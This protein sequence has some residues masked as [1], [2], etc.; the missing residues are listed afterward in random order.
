M[1]RRDDDILVE[2]DLDELGSPGP[3]RISQELSGHLDTHQ[4]LTA[5]LS[6]YPVSEDTPHQP[7][8]YRELWW[9]SFS[10][11]ISV[12]RTTTQP[13]PHLPKFSAANQSQA[14]SSQPSTAL[15]ND[16]NFPLLSPQAIKI[17]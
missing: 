11:T 2:K 13:T 4:A 16:R 15:S 12:P 10:F 9:F 7:S 14:N 3:P 17:N 1:V 8:K 6:D 5:T